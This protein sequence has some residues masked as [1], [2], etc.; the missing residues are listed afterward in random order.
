MSKARMI[1]ED[2][3]IRLRVWV[4]EVDTSIYSRF[5]HFH[6][7][8]IVLFSFSTFFPFDIFPFGLSTANPTEYLQ[9]VHYHLIFTKILS[10]K[11]KV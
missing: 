9:H 4:R 6:L 11:R 3:D 8:T 5:R 1:S 2:E 7:S 10:Q